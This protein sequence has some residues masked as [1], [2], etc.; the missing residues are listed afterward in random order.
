[1]KKIFLFLRVLLLS[2]FFLTG[3]QSNGQS[4]FI[5]PGIS[6]KKSDLD[7]MKSM[8][9]AGIEPWKSSYLSLA[10]SQYASYNYSVRGNSSTTQ[11]INVSTMSGFNYESIKFDGL[12]AHLNAIMWYITGDERHAQKAVEIFNAWSN[13][14]AIKTSGTRSLD[15]GR[16]IW[17]MLEGAEIIKS[18]YSGWSLAD[19]NRFKAMLVYPGYS[20]T[21]VPT[22]AINNEEVS[23]YWFM[24]NGDSGRHGNQGIFG[25]RGIAAMGIFLDNRVMYDRAI[26]YLK[27]LPHRADDLA[28]PS[29][30]PINGATPTSASNE[31][32]NVYSLSGF[33]NTV[34]DYGYNE[35]IANYVYENGQCQ[36]S[37]RDQSHSLN[38]IGN[39]LTIAEMAWNQGDDLYG[40]LDNRLLLGMEY[41]YRYNVS[42]NYSYPDQLTPWEPTVASGEFFDRRERTGRWQSLKMNPTNEGMT[43]TSRAVGFKFDKAPIGEMTLGHYR[44]RLGL[45]SDKYKW[46]Q[47]AFDISTQELGYEGQG[48]DV[49]YPG[50]GGLTFHRPNLCSGDPCSIVDGKRVF[51]IN[52]I[53]GT[54]EAENFDFIPI[55]GQDKTYFENTSTNI[56]GQYRTTE[57][58]DI[59][60]CTEGGNNLTS[61]ENGE[62]VN[63]TVNV[64]TSGRYKLDIRYASMA[65]GGKIKIEY[66]GIDK[67]GEFDI[68]FGGVNSTG[69]QDWKTLTVAPNFTLHAGVQSMRLKISGNS[70]AFQLNN[71]SISYLGAL[72]TQTITFPS[73]T[74][75]TIGTADFDP[76]AT[77][78]AGLAI[79][80][81][82]SNPAVATIVNGL[83]HIVGS[84]ST[85]ITASQGGDENYAPATSINRTFLVTGI[86]AGDYISTGNMNWNGGT[87]SISDGNGGVS[88]TTTT[89]PTS[90]VNVHILSGHTVTLA[91]TAGNCK[92][93]TVQSG[94]TLTETIALT[95]VGNLVMDGTMTNT[96]A[97]TANS[98][99]FVG[100]I[101]TASGNL[102]IAKSFTLQSSGVYKSSTAP[103]GSVFSL[104]INGNDAIVRIDGTLGGTTS[105]NST[106][107]EGL[108]LYFGGT[109]V[110]TLTGTGVVN[111]ARFQPVSGNNNVQN[112]VIDIDMNLGNNSVQSSGVN[113]FSLNAGS[114]TKTLTI[115]T[116]KTVK[117]TNSSGSFHSPTNATE[118]NT[119][120]A[121]KL[122]GTN[123]Y[124]NMTYNINGTLDVSL[125]HF[126][127][128][129]HTNT[130]NPSASQ[131][132]TVN[133]GTQGILKLGSDIR[134][135]KSVATQKI[136]V[137][138]ADGGVI[139]ATTA[140]LNLT[141]APVSANGHTTNNSGLSWF[142]LAPSA[143][144][145]QNVSSGVNTP[146]W[147]G[148]TNT[149]YNPLRINPTTSTTVEVKVQNGFSPSGLLTATTE[150][151]IN[152]TWNITPT[153]AS[154][155]TLS[156][157]YNA[158]DKNT[159][160]NPASS[161][162][163]LHYNQTNATWENLASSTP[164]AGIG[165]DY[166]VSYNNISSFSPFVLGNVFTIPVSITNL[167]TFYCQTAS[168]VLLTSSPTGGTFTID[169]NAATALKPNE[170]SIGTHTIV[171]T[172]SDGESTDTKTVQIGVSAPTISVS[173]SLICKG[174]NATL[175][176]NNCTGTVTWSTGAT[177]NSLVVN[178]QLTSNYKAICSENGCN[179][180]SSL[181]TTVTVN[182]PNIPTVANDISII[183]Q[184]PTTLTATGCEG[185]LIW[186]N[187]GNN[188]EVSMPI[189]P[190]STQVY[191]AKCSQTVN[192]L[193]CL[194]SQSTNI[195][196]N[197]GSIIISIAS[198]DW[199]NAS[200]WNLNRVP[201]S[202]DFVV[203]DSSHTVTISTANATANKLAYR[204][205][206]Q[207]NFANTTAKL[208]MGN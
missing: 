33:E 84:G 85:T 8:V 11:L 52:Q 169:G 89:A 149:N 47:R 111:I 138:V 23:F 81:T 167:N 134:M 143:I 75:K 68:P 164:V 203:I 181:V 1:M 94:A 183:S 6:H 128:Y 54:I 132:L 194:S 112:F 35:L 200:T 51:A 153:I 137:N 118:D 195:T 161:M 113:T 71:F 204:Q 160:N 154:S 106:V 43:A 127:L 13:I 36:E 141:V 201:S 158:T 97:I 79:T 19:Q 151:A 125:A 156:F 206:A 163:L 140:P 90:A 123:N 27:G 122:G 20:T 48:F 10:S 101:W 188:Q 202:T 87:W 63:Y 57:A 131:I 93:L 65:T 100:G 155:S 53:P 17:K 56:G 174:E 170:L 16:V 197:V 102:T 166:S 165:T 12:A 115:N 44:D 34:E 184:T 119:T 136:Y 49:D 133:V 78:S 135:A 146:L 192:G 41:S 95:V 15:A 99:V 83:I 150:K 98:D 39:I 42:L 108:R 148:T 18:T 91:T 189:A 191:Y 82:S 173:N 103:S 9:A 139:D 25:M 207:I 4:T 59:E 196:V 175:S 2:A 208:V 168:E 32:L 193:T 30:P 107:G 116:G 72:P 5:H 120:A 172:H 26:R 24:Y 190:E 182:S 61:L 129:N 185:T 80:Y 67:T 70:N 114:G 58:V 147:V 199:E 55:D 37:A 69:S 198:G 186:F 28:Y 50:W 110:V 66:K 178:P 152:R 142:T 3:W 7:R 162:K 62:W 171:Y 117:I 124:G 130:S 92:S 14:T 76:N 157:G 21:T 74:T 31:Y 104:T 121:L 145:K 144:Y 126:V 179:S 205:N 86:G 29:G 40:F 159:G 64:P 45:T 77:S 73:I 60:D 22:T 180:D 176:I 88:G 96:A 109:G 187:A 177:G 38:G 105:G 46:T